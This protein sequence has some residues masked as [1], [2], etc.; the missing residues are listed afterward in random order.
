[1][2]IINNERSQN[3]TGATEIASLSDI[4]L[5]QR[6]TAN[7]VI[8]YL[9]RAGFFGKLIDAPF[10]RPVKALSLPADALDYITA[11]PIADPPEPNEINR[12]DLARHLRTSR[13]LL[14]T[15]IGRLMVN[16]I[17][18]APSNGPEAE[19]YGPEAIGL[20]ES[21]L[22]IRPYDPAE[23]TLRSKLAK[24]ML[25]KDLLDLAQRL[26]GAYTVHRVRPG[27]GQ[28]YA[29]RVTECVPSAQVARLRH[30]YNLL[31]RL[32]KTDSRGVMAFTPDM[33]DQPVPEYLT[34]RP[35]AQPQP[36]KAK[37]KSSQLKAKPPTPPKPPVT[38]AGP[39]AIAA[40][41]LIY[42]PSI[43]DL[44]DRWGVPRDKIRAAIDKVISD[45]DPIITDT[46]DVPLLGGNKKVRVY[47]PDQEHRIGGLL[48]VTTQ[49]NA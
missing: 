18:R 26:T 11:Y 39:E 31:K 22:Q 24:E 20:I 35:V 29:R 12:E 30:A 4:M 41:A 37:P 5:T 14:A 43:Y 38:Q 8:R 25:D 19:Y 9:H 33:L 10:K 49:N 7:R 32:E 45:G 21:A 2:L 47:S 44:E 46:R 42:Y 48:G 40:E 36:R 17:V 34:P 15:T 6:H 16:P 13:G 3:Q 27:A 23:D 28:R 1:M